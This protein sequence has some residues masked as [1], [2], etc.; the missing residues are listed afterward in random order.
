MTSSKNKIDPE[1]FGFSEKDWEAIFLIFEK[2]PELE[3]AIL[4]GSRATGLAKAFSDWDIGF[5][6][7]KKIRTQA[8]KS[9]IYLHIRRNSFP[10]RGVGFSLR[11]VCSLAYPR[12]RR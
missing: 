9:F 7:L 6:S 1:A 4:F 11:V 10:F 12:S 3:E 8:N 5:F 2:Y